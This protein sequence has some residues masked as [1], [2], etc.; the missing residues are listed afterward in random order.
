MANYYGANYT[1]SLASY[2]TYPMG[3]EWNGNVKCIHDSY[4]A[5]SLASGSVIYAGKLYAGEVYLIGW[6][7][8]DDL[9]SAGTLTLGD[10]G[11]TDGT[12]TG[13]A[14]RFLT[15][16]AFTTDGQWTACSRDIGLG[17]STTVDRDFI[18]TTGEEEMSG[19]I[20]WVILKGGF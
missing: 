9:S 19:T 1:K 14:D 11:V 8:G 7:F 13:D 15:A 5:A 16:T 18:I 2:M 20:E 10:L 4:E 6:I 3:P 17:F 12:S